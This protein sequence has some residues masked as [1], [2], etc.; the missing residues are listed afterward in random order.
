VKA[1]FKVYLGSSEFEHYAEE[2]FE[3]K[4]GT[5]IIDFPSLELDIK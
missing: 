2:N 1:L 4:F 3:W 5:E